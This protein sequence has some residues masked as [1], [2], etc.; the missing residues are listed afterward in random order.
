MSVNRNLAAFAAAN[1]AMAVALGAFAA[2]TAGPQIKT[3]L[4]TGTHYQLTHA[5]L[6]VACALWPARTRL[7]G[8]AGW[9]ATSGGLIFSLS[10]A[11]LGVLGIPALGAITPIGGVLMI[12]AWLLILVAALRTQTPNA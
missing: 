2:H 9:L 4:T 11:L 10:L 1:G 8:M 3:L 6:G 7:I 5:L 12:T